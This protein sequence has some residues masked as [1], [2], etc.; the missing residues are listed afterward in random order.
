MEKSI[1]LINIKS[2]LSYKDPSNEHPPLNAT[3]VVAIL[4]NE[5]EEVDMYLI[6]HH[7]GHLLKDYDPSILVSLSFLGDTDQEQTY[8]LVHPDTL[9]ENPSIDDQC[10]TFLSLAF[11]DR[12]RLAII[13]KNEP[14]LAKMLMAGEFPLVSM[15][16]Y[17]KMEE[18]YDAMLQLVHAINDCFKPLFADGGSDVIISFFDEDGSIKKGA[19]FADLG[20]QILGKSKIINT[21]KKF[22]PQPL[23]SLSPEL[24][25]EIS[26][27]HHLDFNHIEPIIKK[28]SPKI[29]EHE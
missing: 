24:L 17:K 10:P 19:I 1:D 28:F 20:K 16:E 14:Y 27:R 12:L 8:L 15:I 4:Q 7:K 25:L 23:Q 6:Y 2:Y 9:N 13:T 18:E 22:D 5:K 29:S 21:F 11:Q 3:K 26:K